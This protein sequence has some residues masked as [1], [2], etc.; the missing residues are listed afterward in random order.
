MLGDQRVGAL[1]DVPSS[2]ESGYPRF[3]VP[4]WGALWG[5]PGLPQEVRSG[6]TR[7]L[8]QVLKQAAVEEKIGNTGII[9]QP[10][11]GEALR[12]LIARDLA[13]LQ[14]VLKAQPGS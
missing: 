13:A 7:D 12:K 3:A 6:L 10:A 1:P 9:V 11:D 5:P 4:V 2:K 8:L 14:S